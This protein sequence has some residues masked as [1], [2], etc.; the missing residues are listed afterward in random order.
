MNTIIELLLPYLELV[1]IGNVGNTNAYWN[2][3]IHGM[4]PSN[5]YLTINYSDGIKMSGSVH[6]LL[7]PLPCICTDQWK[8]LFTLNNSDIPP[9]ASLKF[10]VVS[11]NP[12]GLNTTPLFH[13]Y[14]KDDIICW[15]Q[16]RN[17]R[18]NFRPKDHNNI[19]KIEIEFCLKL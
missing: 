13:M 19:E 8:L 1:D 16:S 15:L 11:I 12:K 10:F 6:E 17:S 18:Y 5:Y 14:K 7:I 9:F 2:D 3:R 4:L